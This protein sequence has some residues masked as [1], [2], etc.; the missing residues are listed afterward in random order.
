M[1][2]R[3]ARAA[4]LSPGLQVQPLGR[5]SGERRPDDMRLSDVE[6]RLVCSACGKRGADARPDFNW[7]KPVVSMMGYR[8]TT[9]IRRPCVGLLALPAFLAVRYRDLAPRAARLKGGSD[10]SLAT[11]VHASIDIAIY[12]QRRLRREDD[13]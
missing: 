6:R 9:A 7:N 3:L 4:D 5:M 10:L 12:C 8:V 1:E 2:P 13:R 11:D